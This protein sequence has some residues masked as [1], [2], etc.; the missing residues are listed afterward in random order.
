MIYFLLQYKDQVKNKLR[1]PNDMIIIKLRLVSYMILYI[2]IYIYTLTIY[3]LLK[4][5]FKIMLL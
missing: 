1:N 5:C 4:Y 2:Y 3:T